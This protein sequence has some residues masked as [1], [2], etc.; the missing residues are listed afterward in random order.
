[1]TDDDQLREAL[2]T[3]VGSA[4]IALGD[5]ARAVALAHPRSETLGR[6]RLVGLGQRL[7]LGAATLA[8]TI[9]VVAAFGLRSPTPDRA[10]GPS[11]SAQPIV[12]GGGPSPTSA[13]TVAPVEPVAP[14]GSLTWSAGDPDTFEDTGANTFVQSA[15]HWR[16]RWFAVGYRLHLATGHVSGHVWTSDDGRSWARDD[17][18]PDIQFD[19]IVATADRLTIVGAHR[20]PDIGDTQGPT[21][22]SMWT[23]ADGSDWTE[24]PLPAHDSAYSVVW[25]AAA[26]GRG[27]LVRIGDVDGRERWLVGDPVDGWREIAIGPDAFPG[28]QLHGII[29]TPDGWIAIGMTGL[30]PDSPDGPYGDP[31]NDFGAIWWSDD[32]EHWT[33]ADVERPGTSVGSVVAVA[34]GWIATGTDHGGCPRCVGTSQRLVWRSDDGRRWSP[35]EIAQSGDNAFGGV[36]VASDGRRGVMFDTD[37]E[38]RLRVRETVDGL[39]WTAVDAVLDPSVGPAGRLSPSIVAVGPDGVLN[40]IDP[41]VRSEDHFWMVPQIALAGTPPGNGATQPPA[42]TPNDVIC[43][44]AGQECGP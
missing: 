39:E 28:G 34:R 2:E 14:W 20:E 37:A 31:S 15:V 35:V 13:P 27:W 41:S 25:A 10:A 5:R 1:M 40:F 24:A 30:D 6:R 29:G 12:S 38:G 23:S 7:A 42:P 3:R 18:W 16:D 8:V 19:R 33:E 44:P 32:G 11:P 22:A 9:V 36:L 21:R 43:E 4:R 26:G 17:S